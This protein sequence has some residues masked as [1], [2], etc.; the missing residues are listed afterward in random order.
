MSCNLQK[1]TECRTSALWIILNRSAQKETDNFAQWFLH[2]ALIFRELGFPPTRQIA[3][4]CD[5]DA[6]GPDDNSEYNVDTLL[7]THRGQQLK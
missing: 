5:D 3:D 7:D 6:T 4:Y 2:K 1:Y